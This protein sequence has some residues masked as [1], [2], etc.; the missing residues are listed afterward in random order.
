MLLCLTRGNGRT[1][2]FSKIIK[3]SKYNEDKKIKQTLL[4]V[5]MK[6]KLKNIDNH[7]HLGFFLK[8]NNLI[9][10]KDSSA[11]DLTSVYICHIKRNPQTLK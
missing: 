1:I 6:N 4:W 2:N 5:W 10:K 3:S 7:L 11:V 9:F 8:V